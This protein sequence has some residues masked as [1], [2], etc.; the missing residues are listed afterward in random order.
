MLKQAIWLSAAIMVALP[1]SGHCSKQ[2]YAIEPASTVVTFEVSSLGIAKRQGVFSAVTGTV[3]LDAQTGNGS[4][5]LVVNARS[6]RASNAATETFVRGKSFL[7]VDRYSE[8]A[9]KA[10]HVVFVDEKPARVDGKLTVRGVTRDVPLTISG[11]R[12]GDHSTPLATSGC[13]LDAVATF[14]RSDFGMNQY[15]AFVSD[16]VRLVVHGVTTEVR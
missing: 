1:V 3:L 7:N 2:A 13:V 12:C 10:E 16:N 8:I 14:R 4:V 5:D 9:Y 11:Y 6:V 15:M